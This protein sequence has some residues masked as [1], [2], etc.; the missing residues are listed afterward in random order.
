MKTVKVIKSNREKQYIRGLE[1]K[2]I[3][4]QTFVIIYQD[5]NIE[6]KTNLNQMA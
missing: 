4:V 3:S 1:I 2:Y 5:K 6:G